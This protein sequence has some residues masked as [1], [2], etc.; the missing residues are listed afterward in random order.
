MR[1]SGKA[2]IE[3]EIAYNDSDM[4]VSQCGNIMAI[5]KKSLGHIFVANLIYAVCSY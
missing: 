1:A 3:A 5:F 2:N 4:S